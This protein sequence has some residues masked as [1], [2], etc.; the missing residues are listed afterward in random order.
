MHMYNFY[1]L[2]DTNSG[3]KQG[4]VQALDEREAET[5]VQALLVDE[6]PDLHILELELDCLG[7]VRS[8]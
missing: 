2:A 3:V 7:E 1:Y 5:R 8:A 6:A 4:E